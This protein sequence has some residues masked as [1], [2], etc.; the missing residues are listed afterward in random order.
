[1][2]GIGFAD[3]QR[4]VSIGCIRVSVLGALRLES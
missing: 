2:A 1:L 3:E 4:I